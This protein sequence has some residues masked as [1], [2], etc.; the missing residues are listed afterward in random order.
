MC[1]STPT[2]PPTG[3]R[4]ILRGRRRA[5]WRSRICASPTASPTR[6]SRRSSSTSA[7]DQIAGFDDAPLAEAETRRA[8][9]RALLRA[10]HLGHDRATQ[11]RRRSRIRASAISSASPPRRYGFGPGDRVYQG[12]SIAFDFSIEELWVP[13]VAGATLV[14]N[15]A[16]TSLFG[17]ELADFLEA[18]RRHLLLLRADAARLDR[19]RPAEAARAADRRRGLPAGAGQALEPAGPHAAQQL[20]PD[21]GDRHRDA[22][23]HVARTSR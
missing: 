5:R 10:L 1:R 7:R 6:A 18:P 20:R 15:T 14:P 9:R 22:R 17:E 8:R 2:I 3:S 19:A 4:Y 21:R 23:P 16:A 11:G 12:M 13:L